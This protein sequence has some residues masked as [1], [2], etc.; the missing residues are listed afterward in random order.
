[1]IE[2][3][4]TVKTGNQTEHG[5]RASLREALKIL[6]KLHGGCGTGQWNE[7][8]RQDR[9]ISRKLWNEPDYGIIL[10]NY[11]RADKGH[12]PGGSTGKCPLCIVSGICKVCGM[13][14]CPVWY[15]ARQ[16]KKYSPLCGGQYF[17]QNNNDRKIMTVLEIG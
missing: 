17:L 12:F 16:Y 5:I 11:K 15:S 1:M 14:F 2:T 9:K 6:R 8:N 13:G 10:H 4:R 7:G 3:D